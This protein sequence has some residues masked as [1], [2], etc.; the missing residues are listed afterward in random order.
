MFAEA[1]RLEFPKIR[2]FRSSAHYSTENVK[3]IVFHEV[4]D[5]ATPSDHY[6]TIV[7]PECI[8]PIAIDEE[9]AQDRTW[10]RENR[11]PAHRYMGYSRGGW[12][13]GESA[14]FYYRD[15]LSYDLP[16]PTEGTIQAAVYP[17]YPEHKMHLGIIK[18]VWSA[19]S[20]IATGKYKAG[21]QTDNDVVL[22][23]GQRHGDPWI[24]Y[25]AL[26]WCREGLQAGERRRLG[27]AYRPC[28][29]WEMPKTPEYQSLC[30]LV[31]EKYGKDFGGPPTEP[32]R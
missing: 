19:M 27:G 16:T 14:S 17:D 13:T 29:D 4:P 5:L 3:R 9:L 6:L 26:Q 21:Y 15:R 23:K 25:C 24:G 20:R 1:L 28:D 7:F 31:E 32:K 8:G 22:M 10:F 11:V 30:R 2:F 12:E 18:R